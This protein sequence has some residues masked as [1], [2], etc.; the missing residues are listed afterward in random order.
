MAI[1][2]E[3]D[4]IKNNIIITIN[5]REDHII[6][7]KD[8]T[9]IQNNAKRSNLSLI[10]KETRLKAH[11]HNLINMLFKTTIVIEKIRINYYK[12]WRRFKNI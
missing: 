11:Y 8:I 1:K 7:D 12:V 10:K 9:I 5:M 2:I 3:I 6:K 4:K